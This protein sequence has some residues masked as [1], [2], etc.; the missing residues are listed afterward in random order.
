MARLDGKVAIVTGAGGGIGQAYAKGL[1]AEGAAVV[2]CDV[3]DTAN[4][5]NIIKQA[6][7]RALGI[8]TDVSD[9]KQVAAMVAE[10]V[11]TF[12]KIDILVN[13]AAIF[14]KLRHRSFL[15][16]DDAEWDDVMRVNVR[17]PFQVA[18]AVVPEMK[19]NQYG[20]IINIASGT[21]MK[22]VPYF[23][24]YVTSK[25]AIIAMTRA[26]AREVGEDNICVNTIAPGLTAS[27]AVLES[28]AYKDG[29]G[30]RQ[31][32]IN[33]RAFK[34]EQYPEDLVGTC[35]FLASP[36]SDFMT[37][38]CIVCDGGSAMY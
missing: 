13:N 10:T 28:E 27:E 37:G 15:E 1:A 22:G 31:P 25:G 5:V 32:T 16:I 19:K 8:R 17:G 18:K 35:L 30:S 14:A 24:H 29:T 20:K 36:D 23:L 12:G 3:I 4:T 38:Q 34:R 11:K 9:A 6:G 33:T 26:M 7:G 21:V 2:V